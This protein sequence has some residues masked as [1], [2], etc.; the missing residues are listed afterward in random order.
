[1]EEAVEISRPFVIRGLFC[2]IVL[3]CHPTDPLAM[4]NRFASAMREDFVHSRRHVLNLNNEQIADL[5][6]N[7]L[8]KAINAIF[9]QVGKTNASFGIDMPTEQEHDEI[10]DEGEYDPL[11]EAFF[12][13]SAPLLNGDQQFIFDTIAPHIDNSEGGLYNFDA[14]GGSGKTFL[15]NVLLAYTRKDDKIA[16]F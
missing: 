6:N 10:Y 5:A 15:A 2:N 9:E 16:K 12:D 8:L 11:A 3:E 14:P 4:F 13:E 1:M 7:D